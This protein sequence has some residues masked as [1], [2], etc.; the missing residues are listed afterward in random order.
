[1]K[2]GEVMEFGY[3]ASGEVLAPQESSMTSMQYQAEKTLASTNLLYQ[4]YSYQDSF[5][6]RDLVLILLVAGILVVA[7]VIFLITLLSMWIRHHYKRSRGYIPQNVHFRPLPIICFFLIQQVFLIKEFYTAL[8][9]PSAAGING[10]KLVIGV[11]V[12]IIAIYG[13]RR[14]KNR[15]HQLIIYSV[16]VL[17]AA[18]IMMTT[19]VIAGGL[20]YIAAYILLC[21]NFA[22]E[23]KPGIIRILLWAA[24][25]AAIIY[26]MRGTWNDSGYLW[27]L[28][29]LYILAGVALVTTA[30]THSARVSYGSFLLFVAGILIVL[31]TARGNSFL[32]HF[33]AAVLHYIAVCTL[34]SAGSGFRLPK[35]VPEYT[36]EPEKEAG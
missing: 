20:L 9:A 21:V 16:L 19:S 24:L 22:M 28:E 6:W 17:T 4:V 35:I 11:L 26:F 7:T 8:Y 27:I 33:I 15:F 31:N 30:F 1:M 34:A 23:D 36:P 14:R 3:L 25:S 29:I 10:F 32:F 18:D 12:L 5:T 13:Y 2:T